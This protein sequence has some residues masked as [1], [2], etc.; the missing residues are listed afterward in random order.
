[1]W[2]CC[3]LYNKYDSCW[4][5]HFLKSL[6]AAKWVDWIEKHVQ[7]PCSLAAQLLWRDRMIFQSDSVNNLDWGTQHLLLFALATLKSSGQSMHVQLQSL[8]FVCVCSKRVPDWRFYKV[9]ILDMAGWLLKWV[10]QNLL[11][12][13][14]LWVA[15]QLWVFQLFCNIV[16]FDIRIKSI[17][18]I[19][20]HYSVCDL[21][22]NYIL[23]H[24][25]CCHSENVP[26]M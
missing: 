9:L 10:S 4:L 5:S 21:L 2:S 14:K 7:G 6:G 8:Y 1:M 13:R 12:M 20:I 15:S 25:L 23:R 16:H 24:T 26:S 19:L 3:C 11:L 17:I 18:I 22:W